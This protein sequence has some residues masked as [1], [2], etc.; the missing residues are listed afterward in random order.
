MPGY[1]ITR[2]YSTLLLECDASR[3]GIGAVLMQ[4]GH[5]ITYES[6]KL[7]EYERMY[8]IYNKEMLAIMHALAKFLL[9][10]VGNRFKV[11]TDHNNLHFFLEY[12]MM[13]GSRRDNKSG[14]I[15]SKHMTLR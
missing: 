2:F 5:P 6:R 7:W 14:S 1:G 8:S 9:Y 4:E 12:W 13:P 15:R 11:K 3:E 10:L